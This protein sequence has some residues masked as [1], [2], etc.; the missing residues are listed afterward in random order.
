MWL[1]ERQPDDSLERLVEADGG[2]AV[3]DDVDVFGQD[4]LILFTQVQLWQCEVAA[5]CDDLLCEAR[6]LLLQSLEQLRGNNEVK[7]MSKKVQR[8]IIVLKV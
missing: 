4:A 7:L 6:L 5:H 2:G 1:A 3:E 8:I